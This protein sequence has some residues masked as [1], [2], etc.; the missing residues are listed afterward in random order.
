VRWNQFFVLQEIDTQLDQLRWELHLASLLGDERHEHLAAD[1]AQAREREHLTRVTVRRR[2]RQ[3]A[4]L[5][6]VLAGRHLLDYESARSRIE[7]PPW[8]VGLSTPFCSVCNWA[9]DAEA[10]AAAARSGEPVA[11]QG[12]NRLLVRRVADVEQ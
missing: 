6:S 4:D 9:L 5:T 1:I 2:E 8:V 11:C 7:S 10:F 12:C 3:R